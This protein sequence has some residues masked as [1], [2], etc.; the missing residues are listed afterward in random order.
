MHCQCEAS[1]R[2][3]EKRVVSTVEP[4]N[5]AQFKSCRSW[6]RLLAARGL[7]THTQSSYEWVG[8]ESTPQVSPGP[9]A[10]VVSDVAGGF[11][12]L[13]GPESDLGE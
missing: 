4:Q 8:P 13:T 9:T 2:P 12:D 1:R 7:H 6:S 11:V 5:A 3:E 10:S